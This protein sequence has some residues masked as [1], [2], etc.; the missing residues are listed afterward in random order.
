MNVLRKRHSEPVAA[1]D[2]MPR[3]DNG[4]NAQVPTTP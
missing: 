1:L 3:M 4:V 2:A